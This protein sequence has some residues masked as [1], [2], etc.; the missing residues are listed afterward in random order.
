MPGI[1]TT[2]LSVDRDRPDPSAID[3]AAEI[4]RRGGLVAFPTETVYGLGADATNPAA[5]ARIFEAKGRPATNPLIVHGADAGAVRPAVSA[6]TPA[7]E[8]LAR[9]FW[10]GPLTLV[11]PRSGLI[12]DVVTAGQGTVGVRVPDSV[13]ARRLLER[14]GRPVA[15]PSANRSTGVSPTRAGHVLNDLD[16]RVDLVLDA[17]P[18]P[19]GI[20]S[21]VLDLTSDPPRVLRP[22]AV[23]AGQIGAAL[24]VEVTGASP[25]HPA[26]APFTSP[27]QMNLH[28]APRATV[29]PVE[30]DELAGRDWE[31]VPVPYALLT[32]GRNVPLGIGSPVFRVDWSDPVEA[33]RDLYATLH[34][35]D[36]EKLAFLFVVLP[37][38]D[39]AWRAVRDRLWRASRRWSREGGGPAQ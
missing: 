28:Y 29:R 39:D 13:V 7:A 6:W 33:A 31:S 12:P 8:K 15:A 25:R 36:G 17:G 26:N 35:A 18:T 14:T 9:V 2:T 11:L 32:A 27:G 5:V 21:T 4:L 38:D 30:P 34:R 23:T 24:G 37:P 22:G 1:I 20:E 19:V 10:P 3:R 16:G